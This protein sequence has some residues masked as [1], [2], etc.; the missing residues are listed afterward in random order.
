MDGLDRLEILSITSPD[1]EIIC[2]LIGPSPP[3]GGYSIHSYWK[4]E[5][6][7]QII[8]KQ[9]PHYLLSDLPSIYP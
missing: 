4:K 6:D 8:P 9:L 2:R 1:D 5:P 7:K 3:L